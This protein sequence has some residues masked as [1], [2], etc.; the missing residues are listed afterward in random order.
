MKFKAAVLREINKDPEIEDVELTTPLKE[1]Q[2]LVKI[3]TS[4]L[5]GAQLQEI[6]GEKDNK[7][8]LPHLMGHEGFG[9]I[10]ETHANSDLSVGDTVV[11]HWRENYK[12]QN[13]CFPKYEKGIA[14]GA[15][16]TLT[17]YSVVLENRLTPVAKKLNPS[18]GALLG[19][20]LT[21]AYGIVNKEVSITENSN[22]LITGAG[23]LGLAILG[24]IPPKKQDVYVYDRT[25]SSAKSKIVEKFQGIILTENELNSDYKYN[26]IFDTTGS[27]ELISN[28]VKK[29]SPKGQL[30]L[31]AKPSSSII[32]DPSFLFKEAGVCISSTQGGSAV[33]IVDIPALLNSCH[34]NKNPLELVTHNFKLEDIKIALNV[35]RNGEAGRIILNI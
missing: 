1:G 13:P 15:C 4:G 24:F 8:F 12:L 27:S 5:C 2:V 26:Y 22:I 9:H 10:V 31:V 17:E 7:R 6:K 28:L 23:G 20:C 16:T 35:M 14:A 33:P 32:V 29:L 34:T 25:I 19:C 21:T 11:I 3:H 18:I 30:L